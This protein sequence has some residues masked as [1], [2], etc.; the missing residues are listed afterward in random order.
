MGILP[1]GQ[2]EVCG[3][4]VDDDCDDLIDDDDP[5]C[6]AGPQWGPAAQAE[7]SV[8]GSALQG[9]P[10]ALNILGTMLFPIGVIIFLKTWRR[11]K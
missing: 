7:A 10:D 1:R 3:N 11:K 8:Q 6:G 5:D 2:G 4:E 9:R